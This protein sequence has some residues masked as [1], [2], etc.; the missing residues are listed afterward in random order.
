MAHERSS[1]N[2]KLPIG[3]K[4]PSFSLPAAQGGSVDSSSLI[5]AEA[6]IV[7]F[8]CNH[9]PYV[10]GS[11]LSLIKLV[12]AHQKEGLTAIA[13]SSND[14]VQYPEDSFEKMKQHAIDLDLPYR[15]LYD[16]SQAVAKA[17]D[18]VCTPEFFLFD[19]AGILV[20]H[21]AINDSPR[22]PSKVKVDFLGTAVRQLLAGKSPEPNFV[23]P[24]GCS[25]KWR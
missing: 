24:L 23:S 3:S 6:L 14:A 5:G 17:F 19:R 2:T 1:P 13:I 16:E 8:T 7:A 25:I 15:Y 11:E 10:K 4:L 21:G 12:R 22:D 20:Y 18:A 9:C